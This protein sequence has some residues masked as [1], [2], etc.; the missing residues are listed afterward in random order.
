MWLIIGSVVLG[1]V[2]VVGFVFAF[3][4]IH[5]CALHRAVK[6]GDKERVAELLEKDSS[7]V[8]MPDFDGFLPV[9]YAVVGDQFEILELMLNAMKG[10]VT[11]TEVLNL[12]SN[13]GK[14]LS[15][16]Q[17]A[18]D[19]GKVEMTRFLLAKGADVNSETHL[20]DIALHY[21]TKRDSEILKL[22]I[23]AGSDVNKK[24]GGGM[25]PLHFAAQ[26]GQEDC[27]HLLLDHGAN[28]EKK[29]TNQEAT[30]LSTAVHFGNEGCV[31]GFLERGANIEAKDSFGR[32]PLHVAA[33]LG[34]NGCLQV[35]LEAGADAKATTNE[36]KTP[37]ALAK[38]AGKHDVIELLDSGTGD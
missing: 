9:H 27:I 33:A 8:V 18:V 16:L 14:G 24:N 2:V 21:A 6:K 5:F 32:T 28:I 35:L 20:G 23:E 29:E 3:S 13:W 1:I 31:R 19:E 11:P 26:D 34:R 7:C 30:P 10:S 17:Y 36:G 38:M 12:C 22:L 15:S 4:R 37:L 25:T